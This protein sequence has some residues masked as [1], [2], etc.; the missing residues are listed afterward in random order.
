MHHENVVIWRNRNHYMRFEHVMLKIRKCTYK[1]F[2]FFDFSLQIHD[3]TLPKGS[4]YILIALI[5]LELQIARW[6]LL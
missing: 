4:C 6:I 3:S 2:D 1:K 5:S